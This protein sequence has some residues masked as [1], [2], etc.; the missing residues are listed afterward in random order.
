MRS[1]RLTT[2]LDGT[3]V[4]VIRSAN[5][6][7]GAARNLGARQNRGRFLCFLDADDR[8]HKSLRRLFEENP[9]AWVLPWAVLPEIDYLA[10]A[11]LGAWVQGE[12]QLLRA[13]RS[14]VFMQGLITAN[15]TNVARVSGIFKVGAPFDDTINPGALKVASRPHAPRPGD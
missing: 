3:A 15:G 6:G 13:T 12:A 2:V 9:G 7:V 5:R 4:Q 11:P 14:M 10:P 8:H 1:P